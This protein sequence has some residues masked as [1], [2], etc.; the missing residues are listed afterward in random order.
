[1]A[2]V[3]DAGWGGWVESGVVAPDIGEPG[4]IGGGGS[5]MTY[6][7]VIQSGAVSGG[8]PLT[9]QAAY[10]V[11]KWS[12]TPAG[13]PAVTPAFGLTDLIDPFLDLGLPG[14]EFEFRDI[15][16]GG[17]PFRMPDLPGGL[18]MA[19][20]WWT[21]TTMFA[22]D[23]L[24]GRWVA[25]KIRR[26]WLPDTW[27]WHKYRMRKPIVIGKAATPKNRRKIV[28]ALKR[29]NKTARPIYG[30]ARRTRSVRRRR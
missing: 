6:E 12:P 27:I 21:G 1:M 3:W 23:E 7:E 14:G 25:K 17:A 22:I 13:T 24:N 29:Y 11:E 2:M 26:R 4:T 28:M 16:P 18:R 9:T 30:P 8:T 15:I 5:S 19:K 20:S 10:G